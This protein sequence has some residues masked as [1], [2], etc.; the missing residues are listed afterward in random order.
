MVLDH[1]EVA[2]MING[3]VDGDMTLDHLDLGAILQVTEVDGVE[4]GEMEHMAEV[5]R[6]KGFEVEEEEEEG[7]IHT[8]IVLKHIYTI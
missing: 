6:R 4:D 7:A 3:E 2:A 5:E 1:G 8:N